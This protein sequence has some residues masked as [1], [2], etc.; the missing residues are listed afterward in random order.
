MGDFFIVKIMSGGQSASVMSAMKNDIDQLY[1]APASALAVMLIIVVIVM[2]ALILR[3]VDVRQ[4][5]ASG[6][7]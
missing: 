2:V 5:L 3:V 4:E 6:K 7:S 1:Y